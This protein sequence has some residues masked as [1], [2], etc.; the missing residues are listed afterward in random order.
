MRSTPARTDARFDLVVATDV[1][2]YIGDL[3][4]VFAAVRAT[5]DRGV[6]CFTVEQLAP[7]DGDFQLLPSLRY[8]H[9]EVSLR[10]LADAHGFAPIAIARGSVRE[11]ARAR[12]PG[13][14]VCL[15]RGRADDRGS[16]L[17]T[18]ARS[19]PDIDFAAPACGNSVRV[20]RSG[21]M[22]KHSPAAEAMSASSAVVGCRSR[23]W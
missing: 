13:L 11:N 14:F 12:F 20:T 1:F 2:I 17:P 21:S 22:P 23:P 18:Q 9:A 7:G 5:M 19:R 6:F 4:P 3:A 10:R 8:A 15:E 16:P